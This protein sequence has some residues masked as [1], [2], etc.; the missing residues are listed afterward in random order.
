M[1]YTDLVYRTDEGI[2]TITLDRPERMN[3]FSEAMI[4]SLVTALKAAQADPAVKVVVITGKGKCFCAGGDLKAMEAGLFLGEDSRTIL[5]K[6]NC[7][8]EKIQRVPL[9]LLEVD[10]PVIA[11]VN[12]PAVGAGC[13]LALMCDMRIASDKASFTESYVKV[14]LVPGDG[15]AYFLPRLVGTAR[16]LEMLWLG[17]TVDACAAEKIGLVNMVVPADQLAENTT[18]YARLIAEAPPVAVRLIK[19]AVYQSL[20][21]DLRTSLDLISSH[22]AIVGETADH[23]EGVRAVIEK[24]K[25][26]FEGR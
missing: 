6:K 12:G 2:A 5:G 14:G 24:R 10:K 19:R 1:A 16:A 15:G 13:D 20:N 18:R 23:R 11:S 8:W 7:L 22:M 21:T 4:E 17:G 26:R 9:T 3:A 25:P